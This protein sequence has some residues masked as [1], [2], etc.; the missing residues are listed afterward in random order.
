MSEIKQLVL[1]LLE[2]QSLLNAQKLYSRPYRFQWVVFPKNLFDHFKHIW[3]LASRNSIEWSITLYMALIS[4]SSSGSPRLFCKI[5]KS[6]SSVSL[7]QSFLS[8]IWNAPTIVASGSVPE[9]FCLW[10]FDFRCRC[11]LRNIKLE[12]NSK[13]NERNEGSIST[14]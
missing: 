7:P 6:S 8:N 4:S 5:F 11:L 12:I 13:T 1:I 2:L 9:I 10:I 3:I 14:N